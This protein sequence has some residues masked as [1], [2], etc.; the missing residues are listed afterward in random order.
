MDQELNFSLSYEL[1]TR[2]AEQEIRK[3]DSRQDCSDYALELSRASDIL[4]FWFILALGGYPGIPDMDR[5]DADRLR[6][7]GLIRGLRE[8]RE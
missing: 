1:L 8:D 6:L 3:C 4:R 2:T 7:E 5:I